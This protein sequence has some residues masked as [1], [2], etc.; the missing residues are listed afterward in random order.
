MTKNV[1]RHC[2]NGKA[3]GSDG[4]SYEFFKCLPQNWLLYLENLFNK[5]LVTETVHK[6]WG[7]LITCMLFKK[8]DLRMTKNYRPITLINS[9][10]KI[11]TQILCDRLVTWASKLLLLPEAQSGFRRGRSCLDNIFTLH[12]VIQ[13]HLSKPKTVAYATFIDFKGAFPSVN[14]DLLWSKFHKIVLSSKFIR[15]I[16]SFYVSAYTCIRRLKGVQSMLK[17]PA[18]RSI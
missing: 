14:H 7:K 12:T 5:I 6:N 15:I 4:I 13:I 18:R 3:P 8:G 10:A 11:F 9:I 17:C 16:Q 1:N 2:K